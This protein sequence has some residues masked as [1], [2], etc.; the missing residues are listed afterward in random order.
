MGYGDAAQ[1]VQDLYLDKKIREAAAAV[2]QE[3]I[4]RT[5]II[6]NKIQITE[7]LRQYAAAGV[8]TLSVSPYAADLPTAIA[9]LRTL[10]EAFEASGV[11]E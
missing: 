3:F 5:S 11:A 10:A 7:R 1:T 2:P 9:S 8:G 6:G 4:E